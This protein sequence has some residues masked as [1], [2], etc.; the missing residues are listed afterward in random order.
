MRE[1][2]HNTCFFV[3]SK[4]PSN[5]PVES[6]LFLQR[7]SCFIVPS[8]TGVFGLD[9]NEGTILPWST[10][11]NTNPQK[12]FSSV[13][14]NSAPPQLL[15]TNTGYSRDKYRRR[16]L[17]WCHAA[18]H[19]APQRCCSVWEAGTRV[20][21][22]RT[23]WAAACSLHALHQLTFPVC[24]L[25]AVEPILSRLMPKVGS[26]EILFSMGFFLWYTSIFRAE[27]TL[28][29]TLLRISADSLPKAKMDYFVRKTTPN[30]LNINFQHV[31]NISFRHKTKEK[32]HNIC[33]MRSKNMPL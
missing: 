24:G 23:P 26:S 11:F 25:V 8:S 3:L 4:N 9:T 16:Q 5:I 29:A 21:T 6:T 31:L 18:A 17:V 19:S 15:N 32:Q 12:F 30:V 20:L 22:P 2:I 28:R 7:S 33:C 10:A 14:H 13:R 27:L 1:V